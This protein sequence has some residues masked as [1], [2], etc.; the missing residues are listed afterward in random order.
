MRLFYLDRFK[1]L[2]GIS[3]TGIVAYGCELSDGTCALSWQSA[4]PS[5]CFRSSL[6]A[7][8]EVHGHNGATKLQL[9][10]L[11]SE[12]GNPPK[13][14]WLGHTEN[15]FGLSGVGVVAEC[16]KF[17]NDWT[18]M[19]W[20]VPPYGVEVFPTLDSWAAV[21]WSKPHTYTLNSLEFTHDPSTSLLNLEAYRW[22]RRWKGGVWYFI[23]SPPVPHLHQAWTRKSFSDERL[24]GV[25]VY[26]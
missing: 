20:L 22:Y 13:V 25:E 7:V 23:Q 2:S 5:V 21:H 10:P 12:E 6:K 24:L 8:E 3:G 26:R 9:L 17:P 4:T 15:K 14:F 11:T 18:V 19:R 16:C 1:D